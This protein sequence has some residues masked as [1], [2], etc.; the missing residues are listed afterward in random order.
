MQPDYTKK[1]NARKQQNIYQKFGPPNDKQ[2]GKN[3]AQ[4][5]TLPPIQH[6]TL[7]ATPQS[8]NCSLKEL[9]VIAVEDD[10]NGK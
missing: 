3:G 1:R 9:A 6:E 10:K 2:R 4:N 5:D 7:Q 8:K